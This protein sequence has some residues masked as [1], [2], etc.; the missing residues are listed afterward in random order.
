MRKKEVK[1]AYYADD[2]VTIFKDNIQ[3]FLHKFDLAVK[4]YMFIFVQ[5]IQ[6]LVIAKES[7]RNI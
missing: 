5:K 2:A 7:R 6:I 3:R 1:I 4:K